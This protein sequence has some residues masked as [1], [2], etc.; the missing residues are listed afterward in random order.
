M[1]IN[2]YQRYAT[3]EDEEMYWQVEDQYGISE[4]SSL[5]SVWILITHKE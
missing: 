2:L 1:I 5:Y 4:Y 3:M